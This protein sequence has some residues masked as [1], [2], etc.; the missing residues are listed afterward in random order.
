[1]SENL[2]SDPCNCAHCE[3][4]KAKCVGDGTDKLINELDSLAEE[5]EASAE[6]TEQKLFAFKSVKLS[7]K[8]FAL[9]DQLV[10]LRT[11]ACD[12]PVEFHAVLPETGDD[13]L[14]GSAESAQSVRVDSDGPLESGKR[15]KN[16]LVGLGL[17]SHCLRNANEGF[18]QILDAS[19]KDSE[20]GV[21]VFQF[22]FCTHDSFPSV[23]DSIGTPEPT[24]GKPAPLRNHWTLNEAV[25]LLAGIAHY[26]L[27]VEQDSVTDSIE[28][29]LET[30]MDLEEIA[31]QARLAP[32]MEISTWGTHWYGN[33][34]NLR[35]LH[36][37]GDRCGKR[38]A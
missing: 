6:E 32:E 3:A 34:G 8:L 37:C 15:S 1:M 7:R 21:Q 33:R 14:V 22:A 27:R 4:N 26:T 11:S 16:G 29:G 13:V 5:I 23:G 31:N 17:L 2:S 19:L 20:S 35:I 30:C 9:L 24:E 36:T 28:I 12:L 10:D 25:E 38:S 18:A